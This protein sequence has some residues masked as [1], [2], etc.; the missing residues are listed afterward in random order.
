MPL[1]REDE[2]PHVYWSVAKGWAPGGVTLAGKEALQILRLLARLPR[3]ADRDRFIGRLTR[4]VGSEPSTNTIP[5]RGNE[6]CLET[7]IDAATLRV[8]L[9]FDYF[10]TSRGE[11]RVRLASVHKVMGG[12]H[13]RFVATCHER[14]R[15]CWFRIDSVL[16]ASISR[17]TPFQPIDGDELQAFI[18]RSIDG[19]S[20]SGAPVTCWFIVR[21][22]EARWVRMNLPEQEA[23]RIVEV[24]GGLRFETETTALDLLARFVVGLGDGVTS[25]AT[26][27]GQR[28][29]RIAEGALARLEVDESTNVAR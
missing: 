25:C 10:S 16:S 28:V 5:L 14:K 21:Y 13:W 8:P 1:D 9:K 20:G 24:E 19:F 11:H 26:E 7:T 6:Q 15:L 17:G 18:A 4:H 3:S 2:P 23:F 12:D 22:P 29:R 27:V